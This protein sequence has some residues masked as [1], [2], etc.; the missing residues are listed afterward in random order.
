M[1]HKITCEVTG[2]TV[3][4]LID[5]SAMM[6][7][8]YSD[9]LERDRFA[10][11]YWLF[12]LMLVFGSPVSAETLVYEGTTGIGVGKHIVFIANDHEYRS[13]QTLSRIQIS[14]PARP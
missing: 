10:M 7:S 14:E 3:R 12:A 11:K 6:E 4:T 5:Q 2:L 8:R 1:V 13:E 9:L